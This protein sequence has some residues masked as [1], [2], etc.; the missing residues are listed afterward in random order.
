MNKASVILETPRLTLRE[1]ELK[2][3]GDLYALNADQEVLKYT[4][5]SAFE[6]VEDARTFVEEYNAYLNW[7]FGRWAVL[8]KENGRFIGWCG[9]KKHPSGMIDLGFRFFRNEWNKGYATESAKACIQFGFSTLELTN[10]VGR[11][12]RENV[13]SIKV[14]E[15]I[16]MQYWK[17]DECNGIVDALYY[18]IESQ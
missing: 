2:D 3:A 16:G 17:E 6:S 4:G 8:A 11:T 1:F 18:K 9:F 13:G 5:D 7:G 12:A 15:K 10:I 14:L